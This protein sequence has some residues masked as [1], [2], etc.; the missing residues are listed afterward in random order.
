[1]DVAVNRTSCFVPRL[2]TRITRYLENDQN[3]TGEVKL[4]GDKT[5]AESAA[6]GKTKS[7]DG[8]AVSFSVDGS[9]HDAP[10]KRSSTSGKRRSSFLT[11]MGMSFKRY[12]WVC[13]ED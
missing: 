11:R 1:L 7:V 9:S 5:T 10:K 13:E 12:V 4:E 2:H 6:K 3:M 8:S